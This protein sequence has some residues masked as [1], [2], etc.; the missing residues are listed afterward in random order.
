MNGKMDTHDLIA[1]LSKNDLKVK[2]DLFE[3]NY[4]LM[5]SIALRFSKNEEQAKLL[6][7]D[8]FD[9]TLNAYVNYKGKNVPVFGHFLKVEFITGAINFIKS[10]RSEYYVASTVLATSERDKNFNL[11]ESG[12]II[13]HNAIETPVLVKSLQ[14]LVPSQRLVFNLHVIDGFELIT[15]S[16]MLEAS[17]QTVKSN[18]EK[19]R[20]NL[21]KNIE[22]NNRTVK[23]EQAL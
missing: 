11:F 21:Q 8:S 4:E 14:E 9:K 22:K 6:L 5:S 12:E 18:L 20:F 23:H 19:A 3:Q 13:D 2:R 15:I 16:E 1:A 17:E 10:I 7:I